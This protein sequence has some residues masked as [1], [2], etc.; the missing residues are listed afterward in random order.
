MKQ[1]VKNKY[2]MICVMIVAIFVAITF[3][4]AFNVSP[5]AAA[6]ETVVEVGSGVSMNPEVMNKTIVVEGKTYYRIVTAEDLVY[7]LR[8]KGLNADFLLMSDFTITDPEWVN[9]NLEEEIISNF[10][11]FVLD[12]NNNIV[13]GKTRTLTLATERPTSGGSLVFHKTRYGGLF[14]IFSGKLSNLTYR[15]SG[16]IEIKGD[17]YSDS[18]LVLTCGGLAGVF[19]GTID[20]C[21]IV[22][23][24]SIFVYG[25][26][27]NVTT[28]VGGLAGQYLNGHIINKSNINIGG[29]VS[30]YNKLMETKEDEN[31]KAIENKLFVGGLAGHTEQIGTN[32]NNVPDIKDSDI[33]ISASISTNDLT[34]TGLGD[35]IGSIVDWPWSQTCNGDS[36]IL[37]SAGL[38]AQVSKIE[39]ENSTLTI[40][41]SISATGGYLTSKDG[42]ITGGL[43]GVTNGGTIKLNKNTITLS[44]R[45]KTKNE[46][47]AKKTS[48]DYQGV[49]YQ[50]GIIGKVSGDLKGTFSN[51]VIEKSDTFYTLTS[52]D[53][54]VSQN[55]GY[56]TGNNNSTFA[57]FNA[58]NIWIKGDARGLQYNN[59]NSNYGLVH[60]IRSYGGGYISHTIEPD[61]QITFAENQTFAPFYGWF[62]SDGEL[63]NNTKYTD[64][65]EV[66]SRNR[67]DY[68]TNTDFVQSVYRPSKTK[69]SSVS[70]IATFLTQQIYTSGN[71]QEFAEEMNSGLNYSWVKVT[72]EEDIMFTKGMSI[73]DKFNGE[74]DG[75]NH[76]ITFGAQTTIVGSGNVALFRELAS[77]AKFVNTSIV[78]AGTVY[79]G[80]Q[81]S[82]AL[83]DSTVSAVLVA[84]NNGLVNNVSLELTQAGSIKSFG[85][86]NVVGGLIGINNANNDGI[87]LDQIDVTV[88]GKITAVGFDNTVGVAIGSSASEGSYDMINVFAK[89]EI[90]SSMNSSDKSAV[91]KANIGGLVGKIEKVLSTKNTVVNVRD[92]SNYNNNVLM[93]SC[94]H[95]KSLC[96]ELKLD[97]SD[98]R[99]SIITN[100]ASD[101]KPLIST[102]LDDYFGSDGLNVAKRSQ[103]DYETVKAL[104]NTL[105]SSY[106]T[107][108]SSDKRLEIFNRIK[109]LVDNFDCSAECSQ[110]SANINIYALVGL[111]NGLSVGYNNTWVMGSYTQ[112]PV[113]ATV[114]VGVNPLAYT[115]DDTT[116]E[117]ARAKG[118]NLL[119]VRDGSATCLMD[120]SSKDPKNIRFTVSVDTTKV[121]TGW[122][123]EFDHSVMVNKDYIVSYTTESGETVQVL[124][125]SEQTGMAVY[126]SVINSLIVDADTIGKL[127]VT[128]NAGQTYKGVRFVL[129]ADIT[130]ST[131]TSIGS[132][133]DTP[134][135]G[136]LDGKGYTITIRSFATDQDYFGLFGWLGK[137]A[138]IKQINVEYEDSNLN[139]NNE[140]GIFGGISA[141]NEGVIGQD[142]TSNKVSVV[143]KTTVSNIR[144]A[145][146]LV[147]VNT[148]E[149]KN[150]EV[151][152]VETTIGV[153]GN[154][155]VQGFGSDIENSSAIVGGAV[156]YNKE[157][158]K[159]LVKNIIVYTECSANRNISNFFASA[160]NSGSSYAGGLVGYN[161]SK[162]YSSVV[163]VA[164]ESALKSIVSES[165]YSA[166]LVGFN[167]YDMTDGLWALYAFDSTKSDFAFRTPATDEN[168]EYTFAL[169]NGEGANSGNRLIKYGYGDIKVSI[170]S[171]NEAQPYGGSIVFEA[172]EMVPEGK[173]QAV[174]FYNYTLSMT[175]GGLVSSADGGSGQNFAPS[176]KTTSKDSLKGVNYYAVFVK[177]EITSEADFYEF[178]ESINSE[179]KAYANY[180][181]NLSA[182]SEINL[183]TS[184][185][186][187]ATIDLTKEFVGNFNGNGYTIRVRS[188]TSSSGENFKGYALFGIVSE[189]SYI[190]NLTY[191]LDSGI[192]YGYKT[193]LDDIGAL[194]SFVN[195]NKG[196]IENITFI[197]SA[198][199]VGDDTVDYVGGF[200]GYNKG[201]ISGI[202]ATFRYDNSKGAEYGGTVSGFI[203]GGVVGYNDGTVGSERLDSVKITIG[204]GNVESAVIGV[205]SAGG[206]IG[207]NNGLAQNLNSKVYGRISS[208]DVLDGKLVINGKVFDL[209]D[210]K[211]GGAVGE[212]KQTVESAVCYIYASAHFYTSGLGSLGG[213]VGENSGKLGLTGEKDSLKVYFYASVSSSG[214]ALGGIVG[215]NI[216]KAIV[217]EGLVNIYGSLSGANYVGGAVGYNSDSIISEI[218]VFLDSPA[219]L[220]SKN[221]VGGLVGRNMGTIA[222]CDITLSGTVGSSSSLN[223]GGIVGH[224]ETTLVS[225]TY[226]IVRSTLKGADNANIGLVAGKSVDLNNI[227]TVNVWGIASNANTLEATADGGKG[228][229]TLKIVGKA[230]VNA[231]FLDDNRIKFTATFI[232]D[233]PTTWY[234]NISI[235][236]SFNT[237]SNNYTAERDLKNVSY[238]VCYYDLVIN[239]SDEFVKIYQYVNDNDLFNGVM[240]RINSNEDLIIKNT[241]NP[242]GTPEHP[243]AGIFEGDYCKIVLEKGGISG[244]DYCGIFG[245]LS[246]KAIIRNL[247][248]EVKED[249]IVGSGMSSYAGV[250][251]GHLDGQISNVTVNAVSAPY[252]L[253]SDA[254]VG[255]LAG[256][257][258]ATA[259]LTDVWT[260]IYNGAVDAVGVREGATELEKDDIVNV[261]SVIGVGSLTVSVPTYGSND[262]TFTVEQSADVNVFDF[263]DNW[264]SD[265]SKRQTIKQLANPSLYGQVDERPSDGV[266]VYNAKGGIRQNSGLSKINFTLSFI[267]LVIR[268]AEDFYQFAQNINT[269]GDNG[270]MFSFDLGKDEGNNYITELVI[271]MERLMPIGTKEHPFTGVF[272]GLVDTSVNAS[273]ACHTIRLVGNLTA[274]YNDYTG[275]FGYVGE[276]AVIKNIIVRADNETENPDYK[277]Q[278]FGDKKSIYTGF[279]VGFLQGTLQNVTVVL[280]EKTEL[281]N[282]NQDSVGGLV[283]MFDDKAGFV[284]TWLVLAENS[285][286]RVAGGYKD[287]TGTIHL[288]NDETINSIRS[289][290]DIPATVYICGEG[291]LNVSF[292][293]V[294][295]SLPISDENSKFVFALTPVSGGEPVFGFIPKDDETE[296]SKLNKLE[297]LFTASTDGEKYLAVFLN[298]VVRSYED[299]VRIANITNSGRSYKGIEFTQVADITLPEGNG[300]IPIGG[301]VDLGNSTI[302]TEYKLVEFI[303]IYNGNGYKII[304]PQ[305]SSIEQSYSGIFGILG[306]GARISN[307][308]LEVAGSIGGADTKYAGALSGMDNGATLKNII[309]ELKK[310]ASISA[311]LSSARVAVNS[312]IVTDAHGVVQNWADVKTAENVWVLAYNNR[313]NNESNNDEQAFYDVAVAGGKFGQVGVYNG[314]IN[315]ITIVGAGELKL[316]FTYSGETITGVNIAKNSENRVKEWYSFVNGT[317]E[318]FTDISLTDGDTSLATGYNSLILYASFLKSDISSSD[319]L[320][321][322]ARD[323]NN[324]YD[325]YGLTFNLTNDVVIDTDDYIGIGADIPFNATFDGNGNKITL[326][327]GRIIKGKY[328]GIFGNIGEYGKLKNVS[329]QIDGQIG[330]TKYTAEQE[331]SGLTNTLYAGAIAYIQGTM[332]SVI[333]IGN[334]ATIDCKESADGKVYGAIAFGY[335][336]RNILGNTWVITSADNLNKSVGY[337]AN[338][339]ESSINLM[340]VVGMGSL[341]VGFE[342]MSG[343]YVIKMENNYSAENHYSIKGWYSNY[344]KDNQLSKAL[345]VTE[346][347]TDVLAGNNGVYY[348]KTGLINRRYE[349]VIINTVITSVE[350]LLSIS[351]DVNKGGYTYENT[352]FAL[353]SDIVITDEAFA[354]IGTSTTHF[355]G[356]FSGYYNGSYYTITIA[357]TRRNAD[358]STT[359]CSVPL[360]GYNEGVIENLSVV[361]ATDIRMTNSEIGVLA[362]YNA[363]TIT[364]VIVSFDENKPVL[365]KGNKVGGIVGVNLAGARVQNSVVIV[366]EKTTLQGSTVGGLIAENNGFLY[367][368]TGGDN[369]EFSVWEKNRAQQL[370]GLTEFASVNLFGTIDV[371]CEDSRIVAYG[372]GAVGISQDL[373]YVSAITVRLYESGLIK[374]KADSYALGGVVGRSNATLMN[375]VCIAKGKITGEGSGDIGYFVGSIQGTAN[376]SW[377]VVDVPTDAKAIGNGYDAVN[378]LQVSG[379]G[380]IDAYIDSS[381]NIIFIN[382]TKEKSTGDTTIAEID[383]WYES[384]G[385]TVSDSIG[386]VD[387]N[388]FK[389][390]TNITGRTI[391][392]VFI[393][394]TISSVEDLIV[395]AKTVNNGLFAKSLVFTLTQD[396]VITDLNP[397]TDCIGIYT[398][399]GSSGFK[400]IFDGLGHT[401]TFKLSDGASESTSGM[402]NQKHMGLFG[403]TSNSAVVKNLNVVYEK[404]LFGTYETVY[405]GGISGYNS[406]DIIDCSVV[407]GTGATMVA[408]KIG[409]IAGENSRLGRIENCSVENEG[410][411]NAQSVV[412]SDN[413][414]PNA[415]AG[416]VVGSNAGTIKNLIVNNTGTISAS[417]HD[418]SAGAT[419]AGG[420]SGS[421]S[422]YI[423]N[424][425]LYNTGVAISATSEISAYAGG[426]SG[427]NMG[428]ID[429]C[430]IKIRDNSTIQSTSG[431]EQVAGGIVGA[432]GTT[433]SNVLIDIATDTAVFD[434]AIG[435]DKS[436]TSSINNVWVYSGSVNYNSKVSSVNSITYEVLSSSANVVYN[437]VSE[438]VNQGKIVFDALL[439]D[440]KGIT[441]FAEAETNYASVL[442]FDTGYLSYSANSLVFTSSSDVSGVHVKVTMRRVFNHQTELKAFATALNEGV[443]QITGK[444]ELGSDIV[445]TDRF[446]AIGT[447]EHMFSAEFVGNYYNITFAL[448]EKDGAKVPVVYGNGASDELQSLF[449]YSSGTIKTLSVTYEYS[450]NGINSA[451]IVVNNSGTI[452]NSVIYTEQDVT[453]L[454]VV[455]KGD[456]TNENVWII[457]KV[458]SDGSTMSGSNIQTNKYSSIVVKGKGKLE[459]DKT[460]ASLTFNP[461]PMTDNT[462]F[463]GFA[464]ETASHEIGI[465]SDDPFNTLDDMYYGK[466][467][468][469]A[470]FISYVIE[471]KAD[472]MALISVLKLNYGSFSVGKNY[473]MAGDITVTVDDILAL[474]KF[475]GTFNGNNHVLTITGHNQNDG[476]SGFVFGKNEG[477]QSALFENIT[478]DVTDW[479]DSPIPMFLLDD[480]YAGTFRNVSILFAT[481]DMRLSDTFTDVVGWTAENVYAVT[482]SLPDS[483]K[484]SSY[485]TDGIGLVVYTGIRVPT[486]HTDESGRYYATAYEQEDYEIFVGWYKDTFN[487]ANGKYN[488]SVFVGST[489]MVVE[490]SDSNAIYLT[491]V[492]SNIL[493][494]SS[495]LESLA[496]A[497]GKGFEMEGKTITLQDDL[498]NVKEGLT[499]GTDRYSFK[500]TID[501]AGYEITARSPLFK[502]LGGNI[503]NLKVDVG[504]AN[505][506][507][508]TIGETTLL[509]NVVLMSSA[510]NVVLSDR[511]DAQTENCW[512]IAKSS[513][514]HGVNVLTSDFSEIDIMVDF[515]VYSDEL[516]IMALAKSDDKFIVWYDENGKVY[517]NDQYDTIVGKGQKDCRYSIVAT[518]EIDSVDVLNVLPYAVSVGRYYG[519]INLVC[520][521]TLGENFAPIN[522]S[523]SVFYGNGHTV[524]VLQSVENFTLFTN[525]NQVVY[526][527]KLVAYGNQH[528][529]IGD[530]SASTAGLVNCVIELHDEATAS[531]K[532]NIDNSWIVKKVDSD[533][534]ADFARACEGETAN[535]FGYGEGE[536][537]AII[538]S[539]NKSVSFSFVADSDLAMLGF[540]DNNSSTSTSTYVSTYSETGEDVCG[541]AVL[542]YNINRILRSEKEWNSLVNAI[543]QTGNDLSGFEFVL[544]N[545]INLTYVENGVVNY[546]EKLVDIQ[547]TLN[548]N[549]NSLIIDVRSATGERTPIS[550]DYDGFISTTGEG[551]VINLAIELFTA[552]D[553]VLDCAQENCWVISY[554]GDVQTNAGI[555]KVV[556]K[557]GRDSKIT[558]NEKRGTFVF[559]TGDQEEYKLY[560]WFDGN[561]YEQGNVKLNNE[562]ILTFDNGQFKIADKVVTNVVA[563]YQE[564]YTIYVDVIDPVSNEPVT[565]IRPE[566]PENNTYFPVETTE[567]DIEAKLSDSFVFWGFDYDDPYDAVS[568]N[569][570][571]NIMKLSIADMSKLKGSIRIIAYYS[572]VS[573]DFVNITYGDMTASE[574]DAYLTISQDQSDLLN[575]LNQR[576][577]AID[578]NYREFEAKR[579]I[580]SDSDTLGLVYDATT[581]KNLPKHAGN[582]EVSFSINNGPTQIGSASFSFRINPKELVFIELFVKDKI[583]DSTPYT[584]I[585]QKVLSG[586]ID[587]D[588]QEHKISTLDLSRIKLVYVDPVTNNVVSN[589]GQG[590]YVMITED[591]ELG[592]TSYDYTFNID[593]TLPKGKI[594]YRYTLEN[595]EP[596]K[597][598]PFTFGIEKAN[599]SINIPTITIDYL[600]QFIKNSDGSY[601]DINDLFRQY[602]EGVSGLKEGDH[603]ILANAKLLLVEGDEI[604]NINGESKYLYRLKT[605]GTYSITP[606]ADALENYNINTVT[607]TAKLRI[608]RSAVTPVIEQIQTQ[609]GFAVESL[610]YTFLTKDGKAFYITE[611]EY[612]S[613][614]EAFGIELKYGEFIFKYL[615]LDLKVEY[616]YS[617]N[618]AVP[619]KA[620]PTDTLYGVKYRFMQNSNYVYNATENSEFEYNDN[621]E[622]EYLL[623]APSVLKVNVRK[624]TIEYTGA[625]SKVFASD[626]Q[627]F[628]TSVRAT[629][630]VRLVSGD[631]LRVSRPGAGDKANE[632]VGTYNLTFTV[633]DQS[634]ADVTA[635]YDISYNNGEGYTYKIT[636][637]TVSV[638]HL[639]SSYY[640][641]DVNAISNMKYST[642]LSSTVIANI[643]KIFGNGNEKTLAD[644]GIVLKVGYFGSDIQNVGSYNCEYDFK[645]PNDS[646]ASCLQ[647]VPDEKNRT[648]TI[649]PAKLTIVTENYERDYDRTSD[650]SFS[651]FGKHFTVSGF[652]GNDKNYLEVNAEGYTGDVRAQAGTYLYRP[653]GLT[654]SLKSGNANRSYLLDNYVIDKVSN[655]KYTIVALSVKLNM[656]LGYYDE[657]GMFV[658]TDEILYFGDK[659]AVINFTVD[660]VLPGYLQALYET[661][662]DAEATD[663]QI[664][665]WLIEKLDITHKSLFSFDPESTEMNTIRVGDKNENFALRSEDSNIK[666]SSSAFYEVYPVYF[667]IKEFNLNYEYSTGSLTANITFEAVDDS[668]VAIPHYVFNNTAKGLKPGERFMLTDN[669]DFVFELQEEYKLGESVNVKFGIRH[670]TIGVWFVPEDDTLYFAVGGES[671]TLGSEDVIQSPCT[672]E[673]SSQAKFEL[674]VKENPAI[675]AV[676]VVGIIVLVTLICLL[677]IAIYRKNRI[678][679]SAWREIAYS[680]MWD[681]KKKEQETT[682]TDDKEVDDKKDVSSDD[683]TTE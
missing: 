248:V 532:G 574:I 118:L 300:Y 559:D 393:N 189:Y 237:S 396:L 479:I 150:C 667:V 6:E 371:I 59:G 221:S 464:G 535:I 7:A 581:G 671:K 206:I 275:L 475:L 170:Y 629:G 377:L 454:N 52:S 194:G 430:Y 549:F 217:T 614:K 15:F 203:A 22:N 589:A 42:V 45:M 436:N 346:N 205:Y 355:K 569:I 255:A 207:V 550:S 476:D 349:V 437:A 257:V 51:C 630:S 29:S 364:G 417:C 304:I 18:N 407:I 463:V 638:S 84:V 143:I 539:D 105:L 263:Y 351:S 229:N 387:E 372:G 200:V 527:L 87:A 584:T 285:E 338:D 2:F 409:G 649:I 286:T 452:Y 545:D 179:F 611:S 95:N 445:V 551:K 331:A 347:D 670:N 161:A 306:S 274:D 135:E 232:A 261:M 293:R 262:I 431:I 473:T 655:G 27:A 427:S 601:F 253:K 146:G 310:S 592:S 23:T 379:N 147:G 204:T 602:Y 458:A 280:G 329:L 419:Y 658:S 184:D 506:L 367:G 131:H 397:L 352:D 561:Y 599:L 46:S 568:Y 68:V 590:Y 612:A 646:I 515:D 283:G 104:L 214:N 86:T 298:P 319:D 609:Y 69:S 17:A 495:E 538:D 478:F 74:F 582:Y 434:S 459:I 4:V 177:T 487:I 57:T 356:G 622:K 420:I 9:N 424:I 24:G 75:K 468:F 235:L 593:Y 222:K 651:G 116:F 619:V 439:D 543:N 110:C 252:S 632:L 272:D 587:E 366:N 403:Y 470:E 531:M 210:T 60:D 381:N 392:V 241:V 647:F 341:S 490:L 511:T 472:L 540:V 666:I 223:V 303:G 660:G 19:K 88:D 5:E 507:A 89:G 100:S 645:A 113:T 375:S 345:G 185:E 623:I 269:F 90:V 510:E 188:A 153:R 513:D 477:S 369:S 265:I 26:R 390:L 48:K 91:S 449:G 117:G 652:V 76:T 258:S 533:N 284:N 432:N 201:Q 31:I 163:K 164:F 312:T 30:A 522:R 471:D 292:E 358:G 82:E 556:N 80:N 202:E 408:Q 413:T 130:V 126:S 353:G 266:I 10:Y 656:S 528:V 314:G 577:K 373:A 607:S 334:L 453:L 414:S 456:S 38:F 192:E 73:I 77:G 682:E 256:Y 297:G 101:A 588:N 228:F 673:Y 250:L 418:N 114:G 566:V 376:N 152:Y 145:G 426:F 636:P 416:G 72:L 65:S 402:N 565:S 79:A 295:S 618:S 231:E 654:L 198:T 385:V 450:L 591:S 438:I 128:T 171:N 36:Y 108:M 40:A 209:K 193:D 245:Y 500:G 462:I 96:E 336:A 335:D 460:K 552:T 523:S 138:N 421:N 327:S 433:I 624:I 106:D 224:N 642:N 509:K 425:E 399:D 277:G 56:L 678:T 330:W 474:N 142:S 55:Y 534:Y 555:I 594:L 302:G 132:S 220:S 267:D 681:E 596:K 43:F 234:S 178:I 610:N 579:T 378:V 404:G 12:E 680:N 21:N 388:T 25:Q 276:G 634:G 49:V 363:G 683:T 321:A 175:S 586:F 441:V 354:S 572:L 344:A 348:P 123:T 307:L 564:C 219:S 63:Q 343:K 148:G 553:K 631:S 520:D 481:E 181:I 254:K 435:R 260:V 320:I 332:D 182:Q 492:M 423:A 308:Y 422:Y 357:M 562:H 166:I 28:Y 119:Y 359:A 501:G 625:Q 249:F 218:S 675:I 517:L 133:K 410:F 208:A 149:I 480:E 305:G 62:T 122:Y 124:Q 120:I 47:K 606:V 541:L 598:E 92:Y 111:T 35:E 560:Y 600:D 50:G 317:K 325:F 440:E 411:L 370:C 548:G 585:A 374:A 251:A 315:V 384:N 662:L 547:G 66:L 191:V 216:S 512:I 626:D 281:Y 383:G 637:R 361:L 289:Q 497:V 386:N 484:Y 488:E 176:I 61:G 595:G 125:P 546:L 526:D 144:V 112:M 53:D 246:D 613:Y 467:S 299:L 657:N 643:V 318:N 39:I 576:L 482:P 240:F 196:V 558:V 628:A 529:E 505:K 485:T 444:Y 186:K 270:A 172:V 197:T 603:D 3:A 499:I 466:T 136:M 236:E 395:M 448:S 162:L 311:T 537:Q 502:H 34:T 380:I 215:A 70:M 389:P 187:Y 268:S 99:A 406:G 294:N 169:I 457:S 225:D 180:I 661:E 137:E 516:S 141:V 98:L 273:N 278:T 575:Q 158:Q 415:Y 13:P 154:L 469:S 494:D 227:D 233:S 447:L 83:D 489:S 290:F 282:I 401:I 570:A 400:H 323:T 677:S 639:G 544:G 615:S 264:Y 567:L 167:E 627:D 226:V 360:F 496:S 653:Q 44:G 115:Q 583:Y 183:F 8:T 542:A 608:N 340:K 391:N 446:T 157:S 640:Y 498:T 633:I 620:V 67:H 514:M 342:M 676:T 316:T 491:D 174:P 664:S 525:L 573:T 669:T 107:G 521:L 493:L 443:Q 247:V 635:Y 455:A 127:A 78:F 554:V 33:L 362:S 398:E 326:K 287:A 155:T 644:L 58:G 242:I 518:N 16:R 672:V 11:G 578:P 668:N 648:Y 238:H 173:T 81:D 679:R 195:I 617:D 151:R 102:I 85:K 382:I 580:T 616:V 159:G 64:R 54:A 139:I 412:L 296:S 530:A 368:S 663:K 328:A 605:P 571:E 429:S 199:V 165:D 213:I 536:V 350:Q 156:G 324:G 597:L 259:S 301:E 442:L 129:G 394:L 322:L 483:S 103:E 1:N 650:I 14:G 659:S 190:S 524:T 230:Y 563:E 451:G 168:G 160:T 121:F 37:P 465:L 93:A 339:N 508:Q 621:N 333:I 94:N 291:L 557:D 140:S 211:V 428:T 337:V 212:N 244:S 243:F 313:F 604:I 641:G 503:I 41:G 486:F 288:L 97:L 20:K 32:L 271:D 71:M 109:N 504:S 365:V 519:S 405:F 279:L 309:V 674:F 239:N 461:Y 134:F 665:E